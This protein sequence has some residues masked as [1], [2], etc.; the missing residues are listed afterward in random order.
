[1]C[2]KNGI[3]Y[4]WVRAHKHFVHPPENILKEEI[5]NAISY[6][7]WEWFDMEADDD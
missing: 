7:I 1:M 4:G 5:E 6:E 2:V 3:D